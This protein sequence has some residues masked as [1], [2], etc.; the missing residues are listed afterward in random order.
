[1]CEHV[2]FP[3]VPPYDGFLQNYISFP[4]D[5]S[6]LLPSSCS[7]RLGTLVEPLCVGAEA[8]EVGDV[9]VGKTVVI[10]GA[11]CIGLTTLLLCRA[12]GAARV[13][14]V[15]LVSKP[16]GQGHGDGRGRCRAGRPPGVGGEDSRPPGRSRRGRRV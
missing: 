6:F 7:M 10:L 14:L 2:R 8:A 11:G 1:M 5:L 16:A 13:I 3:S 12:R 4:A 15:R 9:C